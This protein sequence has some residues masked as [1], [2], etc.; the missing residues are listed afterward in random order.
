MAVTPDLHIASQER[1]LQC[2]CRQA[3]AGLIG[4]SL[5]YALSITE[6]LNGVL[7]TSAETEQEMVAVERSM[8]YIQ[9]QP[10]VHLSNRCRGPAL[11]A[12]MKSVIRYE[13]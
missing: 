3:G 9:L 2:L 1:A 8:E 5:S 11:S 6:I 7:T 13:H 10:Q 12:K 4:L